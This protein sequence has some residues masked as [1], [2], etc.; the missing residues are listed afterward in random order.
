MCKL[1][2]GQMTSKEA[3]GKSRIQTEKRKLILDAALEEFSVSGLPGATLDKIATGAG[4]SKPNVLY[5]FASKE[6]IY[7]ALL[8][9]LLEIWIDPL[10]R[11]DPDGEPVDEI[12]AYVRRKLALSRDYPRESRLFANEVIQGAPLIG[13][14]LSGDLKDLVDEK[15]AVIE[16]WAAAGRIAPVDARHLIF[17]V[18]SLTQHY[19]DFEVQ[20]R[21]VLGKDDPYAGALAHLE[22]MFARTIT[23]R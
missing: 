6:A 3:S 5:Y 17:S 23:P 22:L 12:L 18:W 20:V 11:L 10:R 7:T 14:T 15:A 1:R 13:A 16:G 21:A 2:S 4:L 8:D 19:A 9:G